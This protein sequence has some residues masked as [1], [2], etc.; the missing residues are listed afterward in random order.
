[1]AAY[2]ISHKSIGPKEVTDIL[3]PK[4]A[5]FLIDSPER[6][7]LSE[8]FCCRENRHFVLSGPQI[9]LHDGEI[10][11]KLSCP[12]ERL[13][14]IRALKAGVLF[15]AD[16]TPN[17]P[18]ELDIRFIPDVCKITCTQQVFAVLKKCNVPSSVLTALYVRTNDGTILPAKLEQARKSPGNHIIT[19]Y[20]GN[21]G[22][23][24]ME[25][26][27]Y[28]QKL[29]GDTPV[30]EYWPD[31]SDPFCCTAFIGKTELFGK[32]SLYSKVLPAC[33]VEYLPRKIIHAKLHIP[34]ICGDPGRLEV[35]PLEERF[36]S[37]ETS[38]NNT[39]NKGN[40]RLTVSSSEHCLTIELPVIRNDGGISVFPEGLAVENGGDGLCV[41]STGDC[42]SEPQRLEVC[43]ER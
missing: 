13:K 14:S 28:G 36:C 16:V 20:S 37:F 31:T 19:V 24:F 23:V 1:M 30:S 40:H 35:Y 29:I 21:P 5:G 12:E 4:H 42:C 26:T 27:L 22:T 6:Q 33:I 3:I 41:L 11:C 32:Q 34:V 25:F 10:S 9:T 18:L 7:K 2:E 39:K 43:C 15:S 38:W 8:D 17:S